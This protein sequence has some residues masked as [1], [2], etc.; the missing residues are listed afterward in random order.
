VNPPR[1]LIAR[2]CTRRFLLI[3]RAVASNKIVGGSG[4]NYLSGGLL[5]ASNPDF[6]SD[7]I[8]GSACDDYLEGSM[9]D[10]QMS[11][12]S[13]DDELRGCSGDDN[14]DRGDALTASTEASIPTHASTA[15]CNS[16]QI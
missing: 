14:L 13:C 12:D 10:D 7:A 5:S 4:D 6:G 16:R 3:Q 15:K 11:G 9:D 1:A 8:W 2:G